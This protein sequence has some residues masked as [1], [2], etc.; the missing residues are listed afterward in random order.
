MDIFVV[1]KVNNLVLRIPRM[2][3]SQMR[4][5][6]NT[7]QVHQNKCVDQTDWADSTPIGGEPS[8][9]FYGFGFAVIGCIVSVVYGIKSCKKK[10]VQYSLVHG[11]D[12]G[13]SD[14][15]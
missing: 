11:D 12:T 10:Q 15:Y 5:G 8:F 3:R 2:V 13:Q 6:M 9:V 7:I 14:D 4:Y 1:V